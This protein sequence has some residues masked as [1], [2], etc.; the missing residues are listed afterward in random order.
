MCRQGRICQQNNH[1]LRATG[2]TQMYNS[3]VP[4]RIIQ[5]RIGHRSLET[6]RMHERV[7]QQQRL[8]VQ[9]QKCF[10]VQCSQH[11]PT[12]VTLS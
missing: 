10:L 4:E 12:I 11:P 7:N 1:S 2:A 9:F 3:G 6:H 8:A 5:E